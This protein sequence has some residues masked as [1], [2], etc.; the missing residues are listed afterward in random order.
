MG[1]GADICSLPILCD[2]GC[3]NVR[4]SGFIAGDGIEWREFASWEKEA[5][6]LHLFPTRTRAIG[7]M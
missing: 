1:I 4:H 7:E 3:C 6:S 2:S 5:N